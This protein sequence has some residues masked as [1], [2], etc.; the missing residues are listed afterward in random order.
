MMNKVI[1][2][3]IRKIFVLKSYNQLQSILKISSKKFSPKIVF[4]KT[5][6]LKKNFIDKNNKKN[7]IKK[8]LLRKIIIKMLM[9]F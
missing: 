5:K 9:K 7:V 4:I 1:Q 8:T 2:K 6:M 3:N